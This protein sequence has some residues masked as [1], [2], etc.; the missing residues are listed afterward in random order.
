MLK[1]HHR[2]KR[3]RKSMRLPGS[4][5]DLCNPKHLPD[6]LKF[7]AS[8]TDEDC[9]RMAERMLREEHAA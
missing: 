9:E 8:L 6:L 1:H 7:L 4:H 2:K 5:I 3:N